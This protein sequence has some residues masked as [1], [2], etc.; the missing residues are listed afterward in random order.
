MEYNKKRL[1]FSQIESESFRCAEPTI[2]EIMWDGVK[3]EFFINYK[4]MSN[5]AVIFGSGAKRADRRDSFPLFDRISWADALSCTGI[6]YFDPTM[7]INDE[8]LVGWGYGT[9]DRWYVK[10]IARIIEIILKKFNIPEKNTLFYGSSAGGFT[11]IILATM[12]RSKASVINAQFNL[13][14]YSIPR[15]ISF[16][17]K[18]VLKEGESLI[19]ERINVAEFMKKMNY[20]PFVHIVD[21][22]Q[23]TDDVVKQLSA[24]T[25]DLAERK[26]DCSNRITIDFYY[27][28][29]GHN[30]MPKLEECLETI[31]SDL[32]RKEPVEDII[33][34]TIKQGKKLAKK[35]LWNVRNLRP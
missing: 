28:E 9:N 32:N 30:G 1:N 29:I 19:E 22:I 6:W 16:L 15:Q 24:L 3:F 13:R 4:P 12:F 23:S 20:V 26:I 7:Y 27:N 25:R 34:N 8:I 21:N 31:K 33:D 5:K 17:E 18:S 14:D 2:Y 35:V 10:D 11:S